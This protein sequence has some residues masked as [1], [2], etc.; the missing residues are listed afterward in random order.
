MRAMLAARGRWRMFGEFEDV[1]R[2]KVSISESGLASNKVMPLGA[3]VE[4]FVRPGMHLHIG[5]IY[6][7]PCAAYRE[8]A[9]RFWGRDPGFTIS[10]LGFTGDMNSIFCAGIVK[11]AIAT[12]FGDSY[13]MPGPNPVFQAA[14]RDGTVQ[15]ENWT[16]LTFSLRLLAGALGF[17]WIPA[18]S[19]FGTSMEEDN[20][21]DY[22]V[23][24]LTSRSCTAGPRTRRATSYSLHPTPRRQAPCERR[25]KAPS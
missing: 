17:E 20:R 18:T 16:I 24:G 4:E 13:P 19:L 12:F 23:T 6:A 15:M 2:Q 10:S 25:G 3:A 21:D 7:R 8:L 14:Y 9:R 11:K 22:F 1:V 5:H